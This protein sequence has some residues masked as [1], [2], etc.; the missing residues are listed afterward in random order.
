L[1]STGQFV[2]GTLLAE[3]AT[4]AQERDLV[5]GILDD[6]GV[7]QARRFEVLLVTSDAR[8]ELR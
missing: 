1:G 3:P 5:E 6:A 2:A 7:D 8:H 4:V